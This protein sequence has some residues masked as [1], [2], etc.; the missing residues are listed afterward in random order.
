MAL[1]YSLVPVFNCLLLLF[2]LKFIPVYLYHLTTKKPTTVEPR[3]LY[4]NHGQMHYFPFRKLTLPT[5]FWMIWLSFFSG[6]ERWLF[7][8]GFSWREEIGGLETAQYSGRSSDCG[9]GQPTVGIRTPTVLLASYMN[10]NINLISSCLSF[11]TC[12]GWSP[13]RKVLWG[14][15]SHKVIMDVFLETVTLSKQCLT[16]QIFP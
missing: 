3:R 5:S 8:L 2:F 14:K 12:K 7:A 9:A 15:T 16:K 13:S 4:E 11:L 1:C 6:K 10:L